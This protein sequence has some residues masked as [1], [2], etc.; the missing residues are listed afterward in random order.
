MQCKQIWYTLFHLCYH[1]SCTHQGTHWCTFAWKHMWSIENHSYGVRH[2]SVG[3]RFEGKENEGRWALT[4]YAMLGE[5]VKVKV[6]SRIGFRSLGLLCSPCFIRYITFSRLSLSFLL[7]F[8]YVVYSIC[9]VVLFLA[10]GISQKSSKKKTNESEKG[11]KNQIY[12]ETCMLYVYTVL[13]IEALC[14]YMNRFSNC[15]T[16]TNF[17]FPWNLCLCVCCWKF[18]L[19]WHSVKQSNS[20]FHKPKQV[21]QDN[22]TVCTKRTKNHRHSK[23]ARGRN[24]RRTSNV[25]WTQTTIWTQSQFSNFR[26]RLAFVF[27]FSSSSVYVLNVLKR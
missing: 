23:N 8:F 16:Q 7:I 5:R 2:K 20:V 27:I 19:L 22:Q 15:R 25:T 9:V 18:F 6:C 11:T 3:Q 4:C 26:S 1:V 24:S 21:S 14:L 10:A 12:I 17:E 13:A